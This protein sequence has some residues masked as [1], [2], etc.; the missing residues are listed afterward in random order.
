MLLYRF[1][2]I[3]ELY[4]FSA[5]LGSSVSQKPEVLKKLNAFM[6]SART[7]HYKMAIE[8]FPLKYVI[9]V[10]HYALNK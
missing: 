5:K 7:V 8:I 4:L 3:V 2:R 9:V 1:I 10:I 6:K